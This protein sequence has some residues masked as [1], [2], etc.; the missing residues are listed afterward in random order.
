MSFYPMV[1]NLPIFRLKV[2][3]RQYCCISRLT[4]FLCMLL[5]AHS[6]SAQTTQ[7]FSTA[8]QTTWTAPMGVTSITIECWGGGGSG[9][10]ATGN[11]SAGGGGGGGSYSKTTNMTV[12]PGQ[13]YNLKVGA[14][15]A[16]AADFGNPGGNSWFKDSLTIFASGGNGG[17]YSSVNNTTASGAA[18][19]TSG[20]IGSVVYYGGAGSMGA[21][22]GASSGGGGGSAGTASNGNSG[23]GTTGGT[24]V[25]GGGAGASGSTLSTNGANATGV[26]GGGAGGRA[27]SATDRTGGSGGTGKVAITYTCPTYTITSTSATSVCSGT[28][29]SITITASSASL[30]DGVYTITYNLS[31]ANTVTGATATATVSSGTGIFSTSSLSG[32]G[33][34]TITITAIR[35]GSGSGCSSVIS[36]NRTATFTVTTMPTP[37]VEFTQGALDSTSNIAVCGTIGGGGQNDMDIESGNPGG[38]SI[39]QWQISYD[40]GA[41]WS[42]APGPTATATQYVLNPI[43]CD[44]ES[45]AGTYYFRA[46]IA[47]GSCVGISNKI[48]LTVTGVSNLSAGSIGSNQIFCNSGNP[49]AFTQLTAPSGG[50]GT[51]TYQWQSSTDSI[52]YTNISAATA[53]TY[54]AP[55][56]SQTT[57]YRRIT[58]SGGC[59]AFSNVVKVQVVTSVPSAPG[60]VSGYT[61]L[62]AQASG[63]T[64]SINGVS[65]ATSYT[66]TVPSGWSITSGQGSTAIV[67][68]TGSASQ[69][70]SINIAA[71]NVCGTG[72]SSSQAV[73]LTSGSTAAVMSG[74]TSIC[75]GGSANLRVNITGGASP[76]TL[77]YSDGVSNATINNY[78]SS[79]SIIVSP[80]ST[81]TYQL[82]SVASLGGCLGTGNSGT[83]TITISSPGTWLGMSDDDWSNAANWCGGVPNINT[84]VIIPQGT[85]VNP[86]IT[87][88]AASVNNIIISDGSALVINNSTFKIKG[89]ITGLGKIDCS[90]GSL[91]LNA[92]D[93][94]QQISGSMFED[95]VIK[96][97]RISNSNG[98]YMTGSN[99]TIR[100]S[101]VLDFGVSNAELYTNGNLTIASTASSTGSVADMTNDGSL[102]GNRIIGNVT[103]ERFIANH[104]KSWRLM[105]APTSGGTIKS[106]WQEGNTALSNAMNPGYGTIITSNLSGAATTL[107]FDIYTP[108]GGTMKTYNSQTE[109]WDGVSSAYN[110]IANSKG[111]MLFVRG[112][113]SVTAFNQA[114]TATTLRTTGTL[115]TPV[116]DPPSVINVSAD[117]FESVGN[118]YASAI[119]F[120]K[121]SKTGGVQNA[122]YVWDPD[123]TISQ[124]SAYGLGGYQTIVR[125]GDGYTIIPGGGSYADG[126]VLIRSGQ[127]FLVRAAGSAGQLLFT[128]TCKTSYNESTSRITSGRPSI[129][130]NMNVLSNNQTVLLDGT[131]AQFDTSFVN[132][133]DIQ[134]V[135]KVG[136]STSENIG[137]IR[138][139]KRLALERRAFPSTQDTLFLQLGSLKRT[140]Y[141]FDLIPSNIAGSGVNASLVDKHTGIITALNAD[142]VTSVYFTVGYDPTS[143]AIDRFYM[144]L[145][146]TS[147]MRPTTVLLKAKRVKT[148][149]VMLNWNVSGGIEGSVFMLQR[150]E[151]GKKFSDVKAVPFSGSKLHYQDKDDDAPEAVTYYRIQT[152]FPSHQLQNSDFSIVGAVGLHSE[153]RISPNPVV[154]KT[155]HCHFEQ[156][157]PGWYR[158]ELYGSDGKLVQH[159]K[160]YLNDGQTLKTMML[161]KAMS[162]GIYEV[163]ITDDQGFVRQISIQML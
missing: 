26:G 77:V 131:M 44:F 124:G 9:G 158:I 70:G 35:S 111:Y 72:A 141:R 6:I 90:N 99:D 28:G 151:D 115:F 93:S 112:D 104:P 144:L 64:F 147:I 117:K 12:V 42:N 30:P 92:T 128:E 86:R 116:D 78:T 79:A 7:T 4:A 106:S 143:Y 159:E 82:L 61:T 135:S 119:D 41:T 85:V 53:T 95:R 130:V 54:D 66:W 39:I 118:P 34:T 83:P 84:D 21:A 149:Q 25:T 67:V 52:T 29:S 97:L 123:L 1:I 69:S 103:V 46:I 27:G 120:S 2:D 125:D 31:G 16:V 51:Y 62:C 5:S 40:I 113:R 160:T 73:T 126:N 17:G 89:K 137:I 75:S 15:G 55:T 146:R 133:V 49:A 38:S 105:A 94:V 11:P 45:V 136:N 50:A 127:A 63:F 139:G 57:Y 81:K 88:I 163:K 148:R 59:R 161:N 19:V 98:V 58:I 68:T 56:I 109:T 153:I 36:A 114:P 33:S 23:S 129:R 138:N 76:Y 37:L 102:S 107:G 96:N 101:G 100:I 14:G 142:S 48:R 155:I 18:A 8:G 110:S 65:T 3:L 108:A 47:N 154:N 145:N 156:C 60:T 140:N 162:S 121:I 80:T 87:G 20:N 22:L 91:E 24:A 134:D 122:F 74:A 150:S 10:A 152:I 43:Y 132:D 13:T 32:A 157:K 71:V